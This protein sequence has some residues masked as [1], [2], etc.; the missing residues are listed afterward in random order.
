MI[1]SRLIP[2]QGPPLR[3]LRRLFLMKNSLNILLACLFMVGLAASAHAQWTYVD[4]TDGPGG[5][6]TLADGS[7][8][9]ATD[10]SGGTTWRKRTD[11]TFGSGGTIFEG[12]D[13]SPEIKTTLSGL[14]PGQSYR[15][16]V[17]FFEKT[18]IGRAH[19]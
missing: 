9:N 2:P 6:T 18:Q 12:I 1:L 19:V 16:Q 14:V 3:V 13:P 10:S 5:N 17:H 4:A 11:P 7:T 15:V 8:L